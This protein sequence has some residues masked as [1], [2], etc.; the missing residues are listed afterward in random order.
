MCA[1]LRILAATTMSM[2]I[3]WTGDA[4][5][6]SPSSTNNGSPPGNHYGW[7]KGNGNPHSSGCAPGGGGGS[8]N[9]NTGHSTTPTSTEAPHTTQTVTGTYGQSFTG[10]APVQSVTGSYGPSFTGYGAVPPIPPQRTPP[11][12]PPLVP[13][14]L[15]PGYVQFPNHTGPRDPATGFPAQVPPLQVTGSYGPSFTGYAP[16]QTVTGSY[17]PSFTGYGAV[18]PIPPQRTPPQPPP[19]VPPPLL[20]GYVQFPNHTGPRDPAT[21][22]PA[23]VPPQ[24]VTGSYGPS[25][26]GHAPVQT[27]TG[28]YG[29]SFT[30]YGAV[31]PIPPQLTPPQPQPPVPPPLLPGY[32]QFPNHTG[33]RD[34]A[35]G[36]PAQV[37]PQQVT[38]SYGPSFTGYGPVQNPPPHQTPPAIIPKPTPKPRPSQTVTSTT[39]VSVNSTEQRQPLAGQLIPR[40][41]GRQHPNAQPQFVVA[42]TGESWTCAASGMQR[43]RHIDERGVVTMNGAL[44]NLVMMDTL[45]RD[46][47]AFHEHSAECL[48]GVQRRPNSQSQRTQGQSR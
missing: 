6:R 46:I 35:T 44:P 23:Q 8:I 30:G 40:H 48:I 22:F 43:R 41:A 47:P 3:I 38:G 32:V 27:V 4:G 10:Y 25:F 33:P 1:L 28:S 16:V 9:G 17:G 19:L 26:T 20:P 24:Q 18:P 34:P 37:P 5:A 45:I 29:P 12:P 21:G 15:L 39:N 2:A 7:C 31:P 36:F 42:E 14:P 11:Q 13:P